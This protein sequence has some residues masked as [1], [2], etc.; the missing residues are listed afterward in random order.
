MK[1]KAFT[2]IEALIV[3]VTIVLLVAILLPVTG[4]CRCFCL[5]NYILTGERIGLL[6]FVTFIFA[7]IFSI[8]FAKDK[9]SKIA[10]GFVWLIVSVCV[11]SA[12]LTY[13]SGVKNYVEESKRRQSVREN[14]LIK[15]YEERL[16]EISPAKE[17]NYKPGL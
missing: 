5:D 2:L 6:T 12:Y 8:S 17:E 3:I 16:K 14:E 7:A 9:A 11:V 15:N 1:S 13:S 10:V 4:K